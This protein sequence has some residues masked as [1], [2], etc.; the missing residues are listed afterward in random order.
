MEPSNF[1]DSG[2]YYW[3][4]ELRSRGAT[5]FLGAGFLAVWLCGWLA[6]EVAA[7][8][9]LL[10]ML[11]GAVLPEFVTERL[12]QVTT[13]G[14]G[15]I[16]VVIFLLV[17]LTFWTIG[18]IFAIRQLLTLLWGRD[19]VSAGPDGIKVNSGAGPFMKERR[20]HRRQIKNIRMRVIGG[21]I[22]AVTSNGMALIASQGTGEERI[23]LRDRLRETLQIQPLDS[24]FASES[25]TLPEI[26][27]TTVDVTGSPILRRSRAPK[28]KAARVAWVISVLA[29]LGFAFVMSRMPWGSL[30]D[31]PIVLALLT[32]G[33]MLLAG[34]AGALF[35]WG[36]EEFVAHYRKLEVRRGIGSFVRSK[37]YQEPVVE[38]EFQEDSDG[39]EFFS[40]VVEDGS[41]ERTLLR[42]M[43]EAN[44]PLSVGRWLTQRMGTELEISPEATQALAA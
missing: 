34:V 28:A 37:F 41:K 6:G 15:G 43:N 17:W 2:H 23:A 36:R 19:V 26:W 1:V 4:V 38:I 40:L 18:G 8:T 11:F 31:G 27:E 20:I 10:A 14:G 3:T 33:V 22:T 39:D 25:I 9:T 35:T 7:L 42:S 16:F 21:P 29:G 13:S 44:E 32:A 30:D 24:W 5:R 12:P